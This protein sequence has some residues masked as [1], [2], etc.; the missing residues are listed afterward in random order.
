MEVT[1]DLQA[2][3]LVDAAG[4][5]RVEARRGDQFGD[6][7]ARRVVVG[8]VEPDRGFRGPAGRGGEGFGGQRAECLD[9]PGT[10]GNQGGKDLAGGLSG[11]DRL[12]EAAVAVRGDR[13]GGVDQDLAGQPVA[14][15]CLRMLAWT[16][17]AMEP[18]SSSDG[19]LTVLSRGCTAPV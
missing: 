18:T 12:D 16:S 5:D 19:R 7:V 17:L 15:R 14:V 13:V 2:D 1:E 3:R 4:L 6:R 9:Q 10:C 8:G 11:A